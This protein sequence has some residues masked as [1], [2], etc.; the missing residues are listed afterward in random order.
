MSEP[1]SSAYEAARHKAAFFTR[2]QPGDLRILGADRLDFVQR[3]TSNDA[4]ALKP[5]QFVLTTLT[6]P[7]GRILDVLYLI[8]EGDEIEAITLPGY[9]PKTYSFLQSRIFFMDKVPLVDASAD[10]AQID[11]L[12]PSSA[13]ILQKLGV[14]HIPVLNQVQRDR[15]DHASI[16]ILGAHPAIGM[17]FRL[18]VPIASSTIVQRA[19]DEAGA[20]ALDAES[21][22]IL[23]VESG[24]PE[25]SI[26][27]KEDYTPLEAGLQVSVSTDKGC[28]TGQEILARQI[29]Y[30]KVTQRLCGLKI[31]GSP[32]TGERAW[33]EGK[34]VGTITSVAKSPRLGMIG[35][36][37]IKRPHDQV[38]KLLELGEQP[39]S[40]NSGEV[41]PLPF[42]V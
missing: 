39:H 4:R 42:S 40:G 21:Y 17:G 27:L 23:R 19:L 13:E 15:I 6:S 8:Q 20:T 1:I 34:A 30:E 35:L 31:K 36:A 14:D 33:V 28:Y 7:T 26:E 18:I 25:A 37:V 22:Q 3:Q 9:G 2:S 38:G 24:I 41:V 32:A 10:F 29:T 12:G 5:D 11:L 16:R